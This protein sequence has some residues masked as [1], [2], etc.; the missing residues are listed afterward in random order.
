MARL[1]VETFKSGLSN[2]L[3]RDAFRSR[4]AQVTLRNQTSFS[5]ANNARVVEQRK[6]LLTNDIDDSLRHATNPSNSPE[7]RAEVA[8]LGLT[9]I[10]NALGDLGPEEHAKLR[11]DFYQRLA[12]NSLIS[13]I[14]KGADAEETLNGF[15]DNKSADPIVSAA[16]QNLTPSDVDKIYGEVLTSTNRTRTLVDRKQKRQR[17]E[18]ALNFETELKTIVNDL[19]VS[20]DMADDSVATDFNERSTQMI[21]DAVDA[22]EG[23]EESKANLSIELRRIRASQVINIG[24]LQQTAKRKRAT[25]QIGDDLRALVTDVSRDPSQLGNALETLDQTISNNASYLSAAE[26]EVQREGGREEV[27]EATINALISK[28][29]VNGA[30]Q[31]FDS[32]GIAQALTPTMQETFRKKFTDF[33][34]ERNAE[35]RKYRNAI[36][37]HRKEFG[38]EPTMREKKIAMG[39]KG[40]EELAEKFRKDFEGK[41]KRF[42]LLRENFDKVQAAAN[43]VSPAGD[44]S[45][46]FGFMKM[47]DPGSVVRESEFA[48]AANTG[49]IPERVWAQFN[50][51]RRGQRLTATQRADFLGQAKNLYQ[52]QEPAQRRL[53]ERFNKL[54]DA[55]E[56]PRNRVVVMDLVDQKITDDNNQTNE[57]TISAEG[58]GIP[59]S[60]AA[61]AAT[62]PVM[63]DASGTV[64]TEETN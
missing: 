24:E 51:A 19:K 30:R 32:T 25:D 16:R 47:I 46:I 62:K 41:S 7:S 1:K 64:V 49:S 5:K 13:A 12:K 45:L 15:R 52:S 23:T 8:N 54:A 35:E 63:L 53:Q 34:N 38:K 22:H 21:N 44:V 20:A 56:V 27:I 11:N 50:R 60:P 58:T 37:L 42:L 39:F 59:T 31:L 18:I 61:S 36:E 14:N 9:A 4:A 6:V 28:G 17:T 40:G 43:N 2:R 57:A 33:D 55:Y 48:T 3:A 26:E 10:D 29:D